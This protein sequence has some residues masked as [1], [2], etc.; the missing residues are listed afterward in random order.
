MSNVRSIIT[1]RG[2]SQKRSNL[3]F[4]NAVFFLFYLVSTSLFVGTT[5]S[6]SLFRIETLLPV[7]AVGAFTSS[8]CEVVAGLDSSSLLEASEKD[9]PCFFVMS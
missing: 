7:L 8:R 2:G 6:S 3:R 4:L 5:S 9:S 1:Q